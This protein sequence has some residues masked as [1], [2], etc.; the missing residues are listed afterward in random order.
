MF[1][2]RSKSSRYSKVC[3]EDDIISS[4]KKSL[5]ISDDITESSGTISLSSLESSNRNVNTSS[6]RPPRLVPIQKT[7]RQVPDATYYC[8]NHVL[9]NRERAARDLPQ[10]HRSRFLDT[11]AREHAQVMAQQGRLF[12]SVATLTDLQQ[13]L[14]SPRVAENTQRGRSVRHMH[15]QTMDD[16]RRSNTSRQNIVSAAFTEFGMGTA[17]GDDGLLYMVQLFR[18]EPEWHDVC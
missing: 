10:L 9:V 12:H 14:E 1:S 15:Q 16:W 3:K 8:N 5:H 2:L 4:K 7:L 18:C 11:L 17:K 13:R 6:N